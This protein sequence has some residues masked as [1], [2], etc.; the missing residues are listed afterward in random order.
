MSHTFTDPLDRCAVRA[1]VRCHDFITVL[2]HLLEPSDVQLSEFGFGEFRHFAGSL[3]TQITRPSLRRWSS[4][5]ALG[6][7]A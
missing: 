3:S 4:R 7:T 5:V 1:A 2:R 6:W